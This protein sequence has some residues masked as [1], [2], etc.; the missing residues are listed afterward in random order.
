MCFPA[1]PPLQIRDIFS[2]LE[3]PLTEA[4]TMPDRATS[5]VCVSMPLKPQI[6]FL[7]GE[8]Y[9]SVAVQLYLYF[10]FAF[11]AGLAQRAHDVN[12]T[13]A[14]RRCNVMTLIDVEATLY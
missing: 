14:Q 7:L 9:A 2:P 1:H 3:Q 13:S 12:T 11:F 4:D 10:L 6:I 8:G 5:S